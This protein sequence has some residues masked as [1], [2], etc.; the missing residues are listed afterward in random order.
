MVSCTVL[1]SSTRQIGSTSDC[2]ST[3][4]SPVLNIKISLVS[5]EYDV[6]IVQ[7]R[8][9]TSYVAC[10]I[11]ICAVHKMYSIATPLLVSILWFPD[12][13]FCKLI[14]RIHFQSFGYGFESTLY[15]RFLM[16]R[17]SSSSCTGTN[18]IDAQFTV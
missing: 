6:I 3:I 15:K 5:I 11:W 1:V 18:F 4:N 9:W 2:T 7:G 8:L 17:S 14:M 16:L 13:L 10:Y 12:N